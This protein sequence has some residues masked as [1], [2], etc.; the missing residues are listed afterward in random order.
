MI[1][2]K[3][4]IAVY[5]PVRTRSI[6]SLR[7]RSLL[8]F[9]LTT[10]CSHKLSIK[11][12]LMSAIAAL[13]SNL[14]SVS[15]C[16]T[17]CSNISIS[18]W[19]SFNC[20]KIKWSPSIAFVAAKRTGICAFSAWSSIKCITA[21][22]QRCTA[23]L[24]SSLSQKSCR[25]GFSWYFAIWSA[26]FTTSSTPSFFAAEIGTTGTPSNDSIS[27][28]LIDPWFPTTSSIIFKATTIG[29]SISNNC[30]VR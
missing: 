27:L 24:W 15:I 4:G 19:S 3:Q 29:M 6:F 28:T 20:S 10:V 2:T 14:R 12:N 18:F 1:P 25:N 9:G 22:I 17:I 5:F 11:S 30:I 13:R 23:P 8:S 21:W 7:I 16:L 26:C